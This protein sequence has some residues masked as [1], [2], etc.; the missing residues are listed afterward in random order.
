[1][2]LEAVRWTRFRIARAESRW[3]DEEMRCSKSR[4]MS[5]VERREMESSPWEAD[6]AKKK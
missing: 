5:C 6:E 4:L 2:S 1:M 3:S